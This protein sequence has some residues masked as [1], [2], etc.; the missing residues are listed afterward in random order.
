MVYLPE[1]LTH[2]ANSLSSLVGVAPMNRD[3]GGY[4]GKRRTVGGRTRVRGALYMAVISAIRY[5]PEISRF[6]ERLKSK[7]KPGKV[8]LIAAMRKLLTILRSIAVR[9]TPWVDE[10]QAKIA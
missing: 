4:E 5:N 10:I 2:D 3:S 9:Q 6:Y 1:L 7:G 8:A